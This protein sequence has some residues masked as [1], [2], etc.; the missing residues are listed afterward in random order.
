MLRL[1]RLRL[2]NVGHSAAGFKSLILD[3]TGGDSRIDAVV[4]PAVDVIL[5]LRNGGGKSSLLSLFFSLFLPAKVDFIGHGKDKSLADY[6]PDGQVS[7]VIAEWEDVSLPRGGPALVT[8][9]VYQWQDGHRPADP[10][11]GW[12]RLVRRW[13]AFRPLPGVLGLESLPVR[14]ADGQLTQASYLSELAAA[15]KAQRRLELGIAMDQTE[16]RD[17][18]ADL[19]LDPAVFRIQRDMNREEGGITDLFHFSTCEEF[20]DFLI[21]LICEPKQ[22]AAVRSSL[23]EQA[24]KLAQRPARERE[25]Q[26][27]AQAALALRPVQ[28][29]GAE[30]S[31][32]EEE[33]AQNVALARRAHVHLDARAQDLAREAAQA[34]EQATAADEESE[35]VQRR[36]AAQDR[37]VVIVRE[38]AARRAV[39]DSRREFAACER[40]ESAASV[41][42]EAWESVD[43][44]LA[45]DAQ[46][47]ELA[48]LRTLLTRQDVHE[49][50][51]REAMETAGAALRDKLA[52]AIEQLRE[53][54]ARARAEREEVTCQVAEAEAGQLAAAE[55]IG[56]AT[57]RLETASRLL[58]AAEAE[59]QAARAE[60]LV[61]RREDVAQAVQR[62]E[63]EETAGRDQL[64]RCGQEAATVQAELADVGAQR[65]RCG[66]RL[67]EVR[68]RHTAA[69]DRLSIL[70]AERREL[71]GAGRL[72][73]LACT[74]DD[75][76]TDLD[77][78]GGD[79]VE[80][81]AEAA[82][83]WDAALAG[84]QAGAAEDQRAM[85]ALEEGGF[86]PACRDVEQAVAD[87][88]ALGVPAV[89]G[90]QFL[91][92]AF[93][94]DQHEQVVAAAPHLIG[95]VV[96][97]GPV[98][99][100]D[101]AALARR[102]KVT[103]AVV[104]VGLDD[105]AR[106]IVA[107]VADGRG[108]V[109]LPVH[110]AL[111]EPDAAEQE[112]ER[113]ARRMAGLASR[114]AQLM[115]RREDDAALARRLRVHLEQFGAVARVELERTVDRL[116]A[117]M[118]A[119]HTQEQQHTDR[120][121]EL[122]TREAA[123]RAQTAQT[124]AQLLRV[125]G[126]LPRLRALAEHLDTV[127]PACRLD[128]ERAGQALAEHQA[129]A[130]R[131]ARQ[132]RAAA[133]RQDAAVQQVQQCAEALKRREREA[134]ALAALLP[135]T[136][137]HGLT[138]GQLSH[139]PLEVLH[140]RWDQARRDWREQIG[141]D[142]LRARAGACAERIETL[143][144]TLAE[145][146]EVVRAQ[147]TA[148]ARE[149]AGTDVQGRR[150]AARK[151]KQSARDALQRLGVA[152]DC[153][154]R[155]IAEWH[156]AQ[157]AVA[158][159]RPPCREEE[160]LA[161]FDDA[162]AAQ[163]ALET[164][165][166]AAR[167]AHEQVHAQRL[168]LTRRKAAVE[169]AHGHARHLARCLRSLESS[170]AR[171]APAALPHEAADTGQAAR[172]DALLLE[173]HQV[174]AESARVLMPDQVTAW[175]DALIGAMDDAGQACDAA[176]RR[177]DKSV[178][179]VQNLAQDRA[180]AEVVDGQLLER[181][182]C[183][184]TV[185]KRLTE[186]IDDVVLREQ[187]VAGELAEL[188]EDQLLVVQACLGLVKTVLD[189]LREVSRHSRL[190]QGL[191]SWS[192]QQFLSLEI[193][194]LPD[195]EVLARRLSA[196]VDRMTLAV[197][198]ATTARASALPEPMTLTKKLVLA[199]L[200]GRGNVVAKIIKPTQSLD[201]VERDSVTQIQ[202]FSGGELLTV[203]VL[204][205]CTLARLRAAKQDRTTGGGV[206]TLVL[207][208]PF[209]KANYTPF[210]GLQRR[211]AEAHGI[212]L[213][214]TTGSNDLPALERFP[215]IVRLR[216]GIDARTRARYVQVAERYGDV[217]ARGLEHAGRDGI[218]SA[219]LRRRPQEP[220]DL[221][222]PDQLQPAADADRPVAGDADGPAARDTTG[223]VGR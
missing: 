194:H 147:A 115:Q 154:G 175:E 68:E 145:A 70:R 17:L 54:E 39:D 132:Q 212:Q 10:G 116:D 135:A 152:Q 184:L 2:E 46:E 51:L 185:P 43:T 83:Q 99:G 193:R 88:R 130:H 122:H 178:R 134:A 7:H 146:G 96:V 206:G 106:Q 64:A 18:L 119:L 179:Q 192:G 164:A 202:K 55:A 142:A 123:A 183:D 45:L 191:G 167:Q 100:G 157:Q 80:L 139:A 159:L 120:V 196:E 75:A 209:G 1:R 169:T 219:H 101:L 138:A 84:E 25:Q 8:G 195:D 174:S 181:L 204:L 158:A 27:L 213:V 93:P 110:R 177:L 102:A 220:A 182:R 137:R 143:T 107:E 67:S 37:R 201:S 61:G 149:Q 124:T 198:E 168:D 113:I 72:L 144:V 38:A 155:A 176:R 128:A 153:H 66:V 53:E 125:A 118:D 189:D 52:S 111:L 69:W 211:V 162:A 136:A 215:L 11:T 221:P 112:R 98:P 197:A 90:L 3:L 186:L 35:S 62:L 58:A 79:L 60:D 180:Y 223:G 57:I 97:C 15:H 205:Y 6:V 12:E 222:M 172:L 19:G 129:A 133:S 50:P 29:H 33:L 173:R 148:L 94:V 163:R 140:G 5:W 131:Y 82:R 199:A 85:K 20:V 14:R 187:V 34:Q 117:E 91:R 9:G 81:L 200:G 30:L 86:L 151:A 4:T 103:R 127:V 89:S 188:A 171:H 126:C 63:Q 161:E 22:P 36:A 26:F 47:R 23:E 95:G 76:L 218:T 217:V 28:Q 56:G 210:I 216:N 165:E 77:Q 24:A 214:Y 104:A 87:L 13:Y 166:S 207:D 21:D 78:V 73:E 109:V 114:T 65:V 74:Q 203:S 48:G 41:I 44:V 141:D 190:P 160:A 49:A 92:E 71:T 170:V 150:T 32:Q 59:V 40:A 208:N 105:Q 42:Q 108:S 16:W 31:G 156:K 121:S